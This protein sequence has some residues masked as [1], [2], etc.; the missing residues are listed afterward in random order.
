LRIK[1]IILKIL[2]TKIYDFFKI[3]EKFFFF[4]LI[5]ILKL[6]NVLNKF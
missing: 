4:I 6:F 3:N 2:D 5:L 1:S